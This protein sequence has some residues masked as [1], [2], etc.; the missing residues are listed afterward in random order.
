MDLPRAGALPDEPDTSGHRY[1]VGEEIANSATH[2]I[3]AALALAGLV[4]LVVLAARHGT[5][6]HIVSCSVFGGTLLAMY[7]ASTLYHAI[8]HARA[9]GVLQLL[10]HSA[11]YLVIAGT[12]TPFMLVNVRGVSGLSLLALV[13]TAALGGIVLRAALGRRAHLVRVVLYILMGW[14]GVVAFGPLLASVGVNGLAL[15]AGGG[16]VY[17]L[18]VGFY[19]WRG[20]P[21][22]HAIWHLFV[23][24][25]SVLHFLAVLWYVIPA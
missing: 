6:R 9:K 7:L 17:T 24:A 8:P 3:G 22:H 2:G 14:V 11:I 23:M 12:Y 4:V 15:I 25:A 20:L 10:D 5:A 13:W 16:I 21:Y 18:G 1:S 19:S